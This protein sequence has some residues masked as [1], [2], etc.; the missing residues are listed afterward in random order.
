MNLLQEIGPHLTGIEKLNALPKTDPRPG[1]W[2]ALDIRV[3]R[4]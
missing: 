3:G 2:E 4:S 1:I